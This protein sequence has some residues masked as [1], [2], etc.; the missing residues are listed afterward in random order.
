MRSGRLDH[1]TQQFRI[2]QH[3]AGSQLIAVERLSLVVSHEQRTLEALQNRLLMNIRIGEVDEH[4]RLRISAGVDVEV[5]AASGDASADILA[6]VLEVHRIE[7]QIALRASVIANLVDDHLAL[8]RC[9]HQLRH[10][11]VADWHKVEVEAVARTLGGNEAQE[12][13]VRDRLDIS[14][15]VADGC[16]EHDAVLLQQIHRLH[17][18]V[19]V[20]LAAAGIICLRRS[21]DGKEVGD[22][23]EA[24]DLLADLLGDQR[25][26]G[27]HRK[28]AV[29]VLLRQLP[30]VVPADHR[31][32]AGHQIKVSAQL[33]A[34]SDD[35]VHILKAQIVLC[36]IS[37]GPAAD[38]VHVA[39]R[40]GI[41]QNQPRDVAVILLAVR[42]N[43]LCAAVE[44]LIAKVQKH[45]SRIMR[46]R[47]VNH[48]VDIFEPAVVRVLDRLAD[49]LKRLRLRRLSIKCL[50]KIQNLQVK[51]LAVLRLLT[52]LQELINQ[53]AECLALS[54]LRK[55]LH[56]VCH[57]F[58]PPK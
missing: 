25:G 50:G 37:A 36:A 16:A 49:C 6:V 32:A 22:V 1:L 11:I 30:D 13:L 7:L 3:R 15:G 24:D 40:R 54:G 33:F 46:V 51:F 39:G 57:M 44:C 20:S 31:L 10:S 47:L 17:H 14:L 48:L 29:V 2:L 35:T 34:L 26:I 56:Y 4:A 52:M 38:A 27:E 12:L 53:H 19:I 28:E 55:I 18:G 41:K 42:A 45:R 23:A 58:K 5:I 21:L 9:R 43:F 8:L